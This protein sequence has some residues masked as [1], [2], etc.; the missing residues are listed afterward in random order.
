MGVHD[1]SGKR[2]TGR[3]DVEHYEHGAVADRSDGR[4]FK[5][6]QSVPQKTII[7]EASP[8]ITYIGNTKAGIDVN[9]SYW[10][11]IKITFAGAITTI[12]FADGDDLYDNIWANRA[13]LAFS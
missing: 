11:I 4:K 9:E 2:Y 10:R 3:S 1:E 5:K 13:A 8:T 6:V 12:E 7:D